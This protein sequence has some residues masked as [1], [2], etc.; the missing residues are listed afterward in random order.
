VSNSK[1]VSAWNPLDDLGVTQREL[2]GTIVEKFEN[3]EG[4]KFRESGDT[5]DGCGVYGIYYFGD[6]E[7]YEPVS[8]N[9]W[10][11]EIPIYIG[12]AVPSGSRTG[13]AH[14][15]SSSGRKLYKRLREH[16][17]SIRRAENLDVE[18]FRVKYLITASIWIRYCEQ[19]LISYYKPWWNRYIDGFGIHDP[20]EGR[21]NQERSVWD[22][23]HP[24]RK[25]VEKRGL[26]HR[27]SEP[28][29]WEQEVQPKI[30][31]EWS[32]DSIKQLSSVDEELSDDD[33]DV[34]QFS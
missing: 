34:T 17:K 18:N 19:T 31:D 24:G 4:E 6:Y 8:N 21:A 32:K 28:N 33:A 12:K 16:K 26:P 2:N 20:G 22:T 11:Y 5:F 10:E 15:E 9:K 1:V 30:D 14:L 25:W 7:H 13:G 27:D 29:T 3:H 23:L